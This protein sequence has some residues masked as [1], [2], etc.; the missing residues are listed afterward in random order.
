ME[1]STISLV[2]IVLSLAALL[3][4]AFFVTRRLMARAIKSVANAL[5]TAQALTPNTAVPMQDLGLKTGSILS[6]S[7]FRNYTSDAL[8]FLLKNDIIQQTEDGRLFLS[9]ILYQKF[10]QH[11]GWDRKDHP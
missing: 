10:E 7:T 6:L 8:Q 11:L 9:E 2:I 3:A 4:T 5:R 1:A